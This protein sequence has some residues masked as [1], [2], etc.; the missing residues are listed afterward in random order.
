MKDLIRLILESGVNLTG[1]VPKEI[2]RTS[3]EGAAS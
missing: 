1:K 2:L 3:K